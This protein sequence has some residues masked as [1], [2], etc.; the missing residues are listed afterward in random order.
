MAK[1]KL[2][3]HAYQQDILARLKSLGEGGASAAA[4]R[5]GV[6]INGFNWL[7]SLEDISEVLPIPDIV[8]VPQTHSWFLGVA[9]VRGNLYALTDLANYFGYPATHITGN[10]RI[11]LVHGKFGINAGFLVERLVGLRL[12]ADMERQQDIGDQAPWYRDQYKDANGETW[13]ELNISALLNQN[14]FLQVAA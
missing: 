9:N 8:R 4:S 10:S 3:L 2:D 12:I 7:V 14:E 13:H 1:R 11:L 6:S 5:L